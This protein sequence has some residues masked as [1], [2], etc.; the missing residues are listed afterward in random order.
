MKKPALL[1]K[2]PVWTEAKNNQGLLPLGKGQEACGLIVVCAP[3]V[4]DDLAGLASLAAGAGAAALLGFVASFL[5]D[6]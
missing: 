5:S 1:A 6:F 4:A 2:M 3:G